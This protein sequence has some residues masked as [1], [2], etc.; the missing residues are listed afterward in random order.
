MRTLPAAL[1]LVAYLIYASIGG[2]MPLKYAVTDCLGPIILFLQ[3]VNL[4]SC[5]L[6]TVGCLALISAHIIWRNWYT[7]PISFF[8]GYAW[9]YLGMLAEGISC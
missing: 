9:C 7:V 8:G 5:I 6:F 4:W 2:H 3:H 1:G